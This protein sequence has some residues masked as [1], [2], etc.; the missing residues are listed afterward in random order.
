MTKWT[1]KKK[2][3]C[4]SGRP[5]HCHQDWGQG[6]PDPV[7][8]LFLI[9]VTLTI[10][11]I[12]TIVHISIIT[13]IINAQAVENDDV[14]QGLRKHR[15]HVRGFETAQHGDNLSRA[16]KGPHPEETRMGEYIMSLFWRAQYFKKQKVMDFFWFFLLQLLS[17]ATLINDRPAKISGYSSLGEY[18]DFIFV[19]FIFWIGLLLHKKVRTKK[20]EVVFCLVLRER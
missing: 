10:I 9:I 6:G 3:F 8:K 19:F 5:W 1:A 11:T 14:H 2:C 12:I 13:K 17:V 18:S 20:G 4:T 7:S 15:N 16:G